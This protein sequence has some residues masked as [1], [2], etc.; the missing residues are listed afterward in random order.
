MLKGT[1]PSST[2]PNQPTYG[3]E[4]KLRL[5]PKEKRAQTLAYARG[6]RDGYH[7]RLDTPAPAEKDKALK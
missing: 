7:R 4:Q 1:I 3:M 6:L 5:L 2:Q